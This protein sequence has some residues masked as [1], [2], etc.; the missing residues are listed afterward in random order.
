MGPNDSLERRQ[1][2]CRT[3]R[4]CGGWWRRGWPGESACVLVGCVSTQHRKSVDVYRSIYHSTMLARFQQ[5]EQQQQQLLEQAR[6]EALSRVEE[7]LRRE[8][9][10]DAVRLAYGPASAVGDGP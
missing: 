9:V 10:K 1:W 8:E 7:K 4:S 5:D 3:N 6:K 2:G